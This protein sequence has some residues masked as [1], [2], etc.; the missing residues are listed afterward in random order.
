MDMGC[1]ATSLGSTAAS[2]APIPMQAYPTSA[3]VTSIYRHPFS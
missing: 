2:R 3:A 1:R